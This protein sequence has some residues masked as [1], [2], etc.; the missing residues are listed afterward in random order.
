MNQPAMSHDEPERRYLGAIVLELD[1]AS[2]KP[3]SLAYKDTLTGGYRSGVDY[4]PILPGTLTW[5]PGTTLQVIPVRLSR[6]GVEKRAAI[7]LGFTPSEGLAAPAGCAVHVAGALVKQGRRMVLVEIAPSGEPVSVGYRAHPRSTARAGADFR[8]FEGR[9]SWAPGETVQAFPVD[10]VDPGM[11]REGRRLGVELHDHRGGTGVFHLHRP[12]GL[13]SE[14]LLSQLPRNASVGFRDAGTGSRI[15]GKGYVGIP[16]QRLQFTDSDGDPAP[17]VTVER[18]E[19]GR[20]TALRRDV[21]VTVLN[22]GV[23][24]EGITTI[25]VEIYGSQ[26][27]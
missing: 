5:A 11:V 24:D 8:P 18:D 14:E 9:L 2:D 22:N 23:V 1:E 20:I 6:S 16:D 25:D 15:P 7:T 17:G 26:A 21:P 27:G 3:L 19:A 13:V 4:E 12:S 10:V